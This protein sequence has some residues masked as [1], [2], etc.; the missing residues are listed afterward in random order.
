MG[1]LEEGSPVP[2]LPSVIGSGG[3]VLTVLAVVELSIEILAQ[4]RTLVVCAL[5]GQVEALTTYSDCMAKN[6]LLLGVSSVPLD[7]S[8]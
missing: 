8:T 2:L 1:E 4:L 3:G 5:S 6:S 7:N